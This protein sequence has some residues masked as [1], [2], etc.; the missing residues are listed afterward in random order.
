MTPKQKYRKSEKGKATEKAYRLSREGKN[1][2]N[3]WRNKNTDR[4]REYAL[5]YNYGL[6]LEAYD[7]L[8]E[9]QQGLCAICR[10]SCPSGPLCVD[11]DH[12]TG[13]IRGL[14]CRKC[15]VGIGQLNDDPALVQAALDYLNNV[16]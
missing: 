6:S 1:A 9:A 4:T 3:K 14:L 12:S 15:N 7:K 5:Q 10:H 8:L 11:H 13:A 2:Q 16:N